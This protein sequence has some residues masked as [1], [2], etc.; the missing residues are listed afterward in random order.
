MIRNLPAAQPQFASRHK[1]DSKDNPLLKKLE[2]AEDGTL[3]AAAASTV[4]PTVSATA[5]SGSAASTAGSATALGGSG[6]IVGGTG[7]VTGPHSSAGAALLHTLKT[8]GLGSIANWMAAHHLLGGATATVVGSSAAGDGSATSA[9]V[10]AG[11][12]IS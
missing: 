6:S 10:L 8:V 2:D 5:S 3:L 7:L 12:K 1:L 4:A 11:K 9:A